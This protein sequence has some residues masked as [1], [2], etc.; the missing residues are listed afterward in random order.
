[1]FTRFLVIILMLLAANPAFA[2][3][4][5]NMIN[6][7]WLH[8]NY[9]DID[10]LV[11]KKGENSSLIPVLNT[12]GEIWYKRNGGTTGEISPLLAKALITNPDLMLSILA[13]YPESFSRWLSRLQG[14]LF[15]DFTGTQFNDLEKL[16]ARLYKA[17]K[18]YTKTGHENLIPF[19]YRLVEQLKTIKS[20]PWIKGRA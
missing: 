2:T 16:H 17:M 11:Q 19:A 1:M 5:K 12:L 4:S 10:A 7:D 6:L 8:E 3:S 9:S 20:E 15:T 14:T 13:D 18:E